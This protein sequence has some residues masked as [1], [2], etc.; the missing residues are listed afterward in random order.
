MAKLAEAVDRHDTAI[1]TAY[2]Y[3]VRTSGAT[4]D[5]ELWDS[6]CADIDSARK[7]LDGLLLASRAVAT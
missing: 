7:E 4:W 2:A 6:L 5:S 1:R 3:G